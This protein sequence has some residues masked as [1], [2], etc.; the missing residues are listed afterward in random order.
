[1]TDDRA[2]LDALL[3]ATTLA[4]VAYV[5]DEG[6]PC[7]VPTGIARWGERIVMHGSTGSRWMRLVGDG[8]LVAVSVAELTA[9]VVGHSA[10]QTGVRGCSAVLYGRLAD[11]ADAEKPAALDVLLDRYL[12]GR[13]SEVRPPTA[14]EL[15]ATRVLA[16]PIDQWSCRVLDGEPK[17]P[18]DDT[19]AAAWSGTVT[20]AAR[21]AAVEPSGTNQAEVPPSVVRLAADFTA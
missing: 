15:A 13:S 18:Q 21:T 2:Q 9:V 8:R 19:D 11:V 7:V 6:R 3:D 5:D 16:L 1:M 12:P 17:P 4:H 14:K 10:Y 20:V